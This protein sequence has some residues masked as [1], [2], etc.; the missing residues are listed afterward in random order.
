[1]VRGMSK[2]IAV[3][4]ALVS[5]GA[6]CKNSGHLGLSEA[7]AQ[8]N[9]RITDVFIKQ[10]SGDANVLGE[11]VKKWYLEILM[12]QKILPVYYK[13]KNVGHALAKETTKYAIPLGLAAGAW[14]GLPVVSQVCAGALVLLGAK[15][16]LT[17]VMGI[18]EKGMV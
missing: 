7:R 2:A 14:S 5:I 9:E 11:G 6:I 4:T 1:M 8:E 3:G 17:D 15:F 12:D 10:N 18:G 16:F 13:I